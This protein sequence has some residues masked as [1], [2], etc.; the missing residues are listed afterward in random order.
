MAGRHTAA[1]FY[2]L[3]VDDHV[4]HAAIV[5]DCPDDAAAIERARQRLTDGRIIEVWSVNRCVIRME[6]RGFNS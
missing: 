3:T 5:K 1:G 6:P 4:A 2:E